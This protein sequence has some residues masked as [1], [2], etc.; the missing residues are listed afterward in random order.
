[1]LNYFSVALKE[2]DEQCAD[3]DDDAP[4]TNDVTVLTPAKMAQRNKQRQSIV[5]TNLSY[6]KGCMISTRL[7]KWHSKQIMHN[8]DPTILVRLSNILCMHAR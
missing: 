8:S 1:M 3:S 5:N 2:I 4:T 6:K 7:R